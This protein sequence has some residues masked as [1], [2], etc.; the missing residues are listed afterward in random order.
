MKSNTKTLSLSKIRIDGDTQPRAHT[1]GLL[2]EDYAE[3]MAASARFPPVVV[4]F[5]GKHYW[6]ADGFHRYLAI[7]AS[8]NETIVCDVREGSQRDA[9]LYSCGANTEH[10]SRRSESD[11]QHA[12]TKLLKDEK[13]RARSSRWIAEHA[14]V[15]DEYVERLR[16]DLERE[17]R[18]KPPTVGHRQLGSASPAL[19]RGK[20]GKL[21]PVKG[22][23][24]VRPTGHAVSTTGTGHVVDGHHRSTAGAAVVRL[25]GK[26]AR[27][28]L[29][30]LDGLTV[31]ELGMVIDKATRLLAKRKAR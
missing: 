16:K 8:G 5:D 22:P 7:K 3:Q 14:K 17:W 6:L 1:D 31:E 2:I 20:D 21:R 10:G 30:A 26:S 15:D 4:F 18:K 11:K 27:E 29:D 25:P 13:W 12:V 9:V 28:V 23:T 24:L 19:R